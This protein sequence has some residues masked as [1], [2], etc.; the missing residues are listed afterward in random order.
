MEEFILMENSIKMNYKRSYNQ[1][2]LVCNYYCI[3][4]FL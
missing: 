4:S 2:I 1:D 3:Y